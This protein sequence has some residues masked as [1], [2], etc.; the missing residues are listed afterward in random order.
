MQTIIKYVNPIWHE[1]LGYIVG[2]CGEDNDIRLVDD[3]ETV[4]DEISRT[5]TPI[6]EEEIGI[7]TI[8]HFYC[9]FCGKDFDDCYGRPNISFYNHLKRDCEK[10]PKKITG[11]HEIITIDGKKK[12][13]KE[14]IDDVKNWHAQTVYQFKRPI[15]FVLLPSGRTEDFSKKY[16][17]YYDTFNDASIALREYKDCL[18]RVCIPIEKI[19][20]RCDYCGDLFTNEENASKHLLNK[21][22]K[23]CGLE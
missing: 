3:I 2:G 15:D 23:D 20:F 16:H 7:R 17:V 8:N 6:M 13:A 19:Y 21:H 12:T 14:Y 5:L 4:N 11:I 22:K 9:P 10:I 18:T 1:G